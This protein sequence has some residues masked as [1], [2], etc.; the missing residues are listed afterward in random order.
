MISCRFYILVAGCLD[1]NWI[2]LVLSVFLCVDLFL[3]CVS[4][5][6]GLVTI[7]LFILL[8]LYT[9]CRSYLLFAISSIL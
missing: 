1:C 3:W 8:A 9:S 5:V 4:L 6:T 2:F 7:T